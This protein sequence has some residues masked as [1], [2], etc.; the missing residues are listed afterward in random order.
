MFG[1]HSTV[2][3]E[4]ALIH[5]NVLTFRTMD[6]M[7]NVDS[8]STADKALL[9]RVECIYLIVILGGCHELKLIIF[10]SLSGKL[11]MYIQ[12]YK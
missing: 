4:Q 3:S 6:V 1:V 10:C 7:S 8:L 2:H 5:V 9:T 11:H 12:L